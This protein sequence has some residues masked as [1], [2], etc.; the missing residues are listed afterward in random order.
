MKPKVL[1]KKHGL[2]EWDIYAYKPEALFI[3][4]FDRSDHFHFACAKCREIVDVLM[5]ERDDGYADTPTVY[6][7]LRCPKCGS[8]GFRKIYLEDTGKHFLVF[9]KVVESLAKNPAEARP[10]IVTRRASK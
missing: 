7:Y 5:V 10:G 4:V 9:P 2:K 6:F 1:Y 3:P 8:Q